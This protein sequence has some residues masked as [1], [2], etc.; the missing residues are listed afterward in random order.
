M[1][2]IKDTNERINHTL[3]FLAPLQINEVFIIP[4]SNCFKKKFILWT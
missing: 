4:R 2:R 1:L 3:S